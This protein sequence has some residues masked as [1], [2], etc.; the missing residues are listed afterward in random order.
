MAGRHNKINSTADNSE[1]YYFGDWRFNADTGDLFERDN[2]F[3]LESQVAKLLEYLLTHQN[4][5]IS[6]EE[7]IAAVWENRVVSDDAINRCISILRQTLSPQNTHAYIET[8]RRRGYI[9]HFPPAPE[10]PTPESISPHRWRI[11]ALAIAAGIVLLALF[12]LKREDAGVSVDDAADLRGGPPVVAVLPFTVY[13][14]GDEGLFFADGIHEDLLTQLAQLQAF[15][16]ISRT[17]VLEYRDSEQ[18]LRDIGRQLGADAILEGGVQGIDGQV[19]VNVQ[20][21][22]AA[23]DAHLW[24]ETY[25]RELS[26]ESLFAVQSEIARAVANA[27][28]TS[29]NAEDV[30]ELAVLPTQNMA[31]YRAFHRAMNIRD[32]LGIYDPSYLPTLEEAVR[33]DPQFVRAWAELAGMLSLQVFSRPNAETIQRVEEILDR[34]NTIAPNS[35]DYV[36]AQAYYTYYVLRNYEKAYQ[37][38]SQAQAMRPS[39]VRVLEVKS[40]IERRLGDFEG[41]GETLRLAA[42]LDPRNPQ[43]S[44]VS[45]RNLI[46]SHRYDEASQAVDASEFQDYETSSLGAMLRVREHHDFNRWLAEVEAL[47]H[48]YEGGGNLLDLWEAQIAARD[49]EAAQKTLQSMDEDIERL[50]GIGIAGFSQKAVAQILT[51]WLLEQDQ[52]LDELIVRLRSNL[53][54]RSQSDVNYSITSVKLGI[55][56]LAAAEGDAAEAERQVRRW[57]RAVVDDLAQQAMERHYSCRVLGMVGAAAA[58]VECL[59][60]ALE[61]PSLAMPFIEPYLPYYDSIREEA[62][63]VQLLQSLDA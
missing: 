10:E 14:E 48:E 33:L 3:R 29:L 55:A 6:R 32:T 47:Q 28:H 22:D 27:M 12:W 37:L 20:L 38:I 62:E 16:V 18:N 51:Y 5:V 23:S 24:A 2:T 8:V 30:S 54:E 46:V 13:G 19:R 26:P 34:I 25:D 53:V 50:D 58:A 31:A 21:I 63:F 40:Y 57:Q 7:L 15:R 36:I 44:I 4:T 52:K 9:A 1:H 39:D 49:F 35:A 60:A 61:E 59:A 56:L 45:L 42:R 17:S 11:P 43:W 41:R